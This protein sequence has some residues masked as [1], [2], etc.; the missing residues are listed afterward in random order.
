M[1]RFR[2]CLTP[3]L[4]L[5]F[6][7]G[8]PV[9]AA[10]IQDASQLF[11]NGKPT[12]ALEKIN[13]YLAANPKDA[14]GRFLKGL[15]L[16]E[17]NRN[18]DAIKVFSSLSDDHPELP[19]PYNNLAVLYAAQGQFE[20]AKNSLEMAIRTHPSYA[21]A[22]ENLGDIYAK[23][24]SMA[25]DKAL[26]LDQTNASA[27]AK[28]SMIKELFIPTPASASSE[29]G[30]TA[31]K[32]APGKTAAMSVPAAT[33]AAAVAASTPATTNLAAATKAAV[34]AAVR[35]WAAAW[36]ARNVADYVAIYAADYAPR[37]SDRATWLTQREERLT[38]PSFIQVNIDQL[39]ITVTGDTAIANFRQ[40]YRSDRHRDS[41]RKSLTLE[42]RD[43]AWK[44]VAE[45]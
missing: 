29:T 18:L 2:R 31:A 25:Y 7:L 26:Q 22:H 16:T 15:I 1:I 40:R 12:Q 42:L 13:A 45:N 23:M 21:T 14:Q 8:T 3:L 24:A 28:L 6:F 44:I 37:D 32:P 35:A 27:Q 10:S 38:Q 9:L 5:A 43:S 33:P 19:E 30:K 36:S 39:K 20:R 17:M 41:G 11:R 34:E 4:A